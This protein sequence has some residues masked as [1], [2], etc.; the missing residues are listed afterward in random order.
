MAPDLSQMQ[1][2]LGE[3]AIEDYRRGI[4]SRRAVLRR[5]AL[6]CGSTVTASSLLA[7]CSDDMLPAGRDGGIDAGFDA[8]RDAVEDVVA[9]GAADAAA[10]GDTDGGAD[11]AADAGAD[12]EPDAG[13]GAA[14]DAPRPGI[15]SVPEDDPDVMARELTY[16]SATDVRAYLAVPA[17]PGSF[18]GLILIHENRGLTEH[19][20]DVARRFAKSGCVALAPDLA[21]R[22]GGTASMSA[23]ALAAFF[24]NARPEDL[25]ADLGA[26]LGVL[27]K[28][29]KVGANRYGTCGFCFGGG[30]ALRFAAANPQIRAAVVYY[31]PTPDP[32]ELMKTTNAAILGQY[33]ALDDRVNA[34]IP[35]LERVM[36]EAGKT[37]EKRLYAGAGH[38]FNND[39]GPGYDEDAAVA[40]WPFTIGWFERSL[41]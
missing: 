40:A 27:A 23:D 30:Y 39:T 11:G 41:G 5:L 22:A 33:G 20:K 8:G 34:S 17:F 4:L 28:E 14:A 16:R 36:M 19:I 35:A 25:I 29:P 9:D 2:Y 32:P 24:A 37:F 38:G 15:M 3:E 12:A 13:A 6:I 7:A 18:A 21:S 31:G 1:R 10:G 26:A